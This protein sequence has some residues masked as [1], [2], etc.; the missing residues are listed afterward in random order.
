MLF[1]KGN[2]LGRKIKKGE[3]WILGKKLPLVRRLGCTGEKHY[4]WKG[5][6]NP[7]TI[8]I[9]KSFEYRQWRCDVFQRDNYI[10]QQCG[11]DKGG[12]LEAHH[13]I[14]FCKIIKKYNIKTFEE[15]INCAELWNINNGIT[16][17]K[18][19]HRY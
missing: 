16:L 14:S 17:C 10:C 6:R 13:I 5:G 19:C 8:Q 15:A 4:N 12:I 9:R 11:Y 7:L 3:K 18:H 1:Q 2:K